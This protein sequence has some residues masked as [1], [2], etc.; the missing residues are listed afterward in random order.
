MNFAFA[1]T[2]RK[3]TQGIENVCSSVELVVNGKLERNLI[4]D[5]MHDLYAQFWHHERVILTFASKEPKT[6]SP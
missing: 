1:G 5:F 6:R 2:F 4:S 3:Q